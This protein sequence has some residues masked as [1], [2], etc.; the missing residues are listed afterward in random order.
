MA[1]CSANKVLYTVLA[2]AGLS[3]RA[4]AQT[5]DLVVDYLNGFALAASSGRLGKPGERQNLLTRLDEQLEQF[6]TQS[7]V[8]SSITQ[9]ETLA[10]IKVELNIILKGIEAIAVGC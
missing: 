8:F 6:P 1:T 4:I 9:E 5:A 3:P 2:K 7:W 10:D